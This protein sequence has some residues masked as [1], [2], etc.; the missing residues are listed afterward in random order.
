MTIASSIVSN[1]CKY[2]ESFL[3][4]ENFAGPEIDWENTQWKKKPYN[5]KNAFKMGLHFTNHS[6]IYLHL[7]HS[8][9]YMCTLLI[10]P[11]EWMFAYLLCWVTLHILLELNEVQNDKAG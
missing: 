8:D 1:L 5:F 11:T 2:R 7:N 9:T 6:T 3:T 10:Q 4:W